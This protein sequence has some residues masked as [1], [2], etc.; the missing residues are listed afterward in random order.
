MKYAK[1]DDLLS[2]LLQLEKRIMKKLNVATFGL[3]TELNTIEKTCYVKTFPSDDNN[4]IACKYPDDMEINLTI[5][6]IVIVLFIDKDFRQH[7]KLV[8]NGNLD[9]KTQ[10]SEILHSDISG[11]IIQIFKKGGI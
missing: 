8:E 5:N 3:V 11:V 7:L 4:E 6:S 2:V 9:A 10:I 1:Q